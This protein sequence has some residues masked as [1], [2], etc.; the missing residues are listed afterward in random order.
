MCTMLLY[1]LSKHKKILDK[2]RAE[3]KE[4]FSS[5]GVEDITE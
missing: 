1:T 4:V 5:D 2:L 3:I